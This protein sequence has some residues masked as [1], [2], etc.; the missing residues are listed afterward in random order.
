MEM[1]H[2]PQL[3]ELQE[4]IDRIKT[5]KATRRD[6]DRG[7]ELAKSNRFHILNDPKLKE[8]VK[9]CLFPY[10]IYKQADEIASN[11]IIKKGKDL[12]KYIS[13]LREKR[14]GDFV[15]EGKNDCYDFLMHLA[16]D[17]AFEIGIIPDKKEIWKE[18]FVDQNGKKN[19]KEIQ[20]FF[21]F[22]RCWCRINWTRKG[23]DLSTYWTKSWK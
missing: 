12:E 11:L 21:L 16:T 14:F 7:Y 9:Q 8:Q 17:A 2:S 13:D 22:K 5:N 4:I 20:S 23:C 15:R 3:K 18:T 10:A 19:K 1:I 6:L